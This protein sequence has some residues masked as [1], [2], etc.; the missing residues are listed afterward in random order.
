MFQ[1]NEIW[2]VPGPAQTILYRPLA[3]ISDGNLGCLVWSPPLIFP[4]TYSFPSLIL[5][6]TDPRFPEEAVGPD[7]RAGPTRLLLDFTVVWA[8]GQNSRH[9]FF[10][11]TYFFPS[12]IL[13][14]TDP[15]VAW[16]W[17]SVTYFLPSLI[18]FRHLFSRAACKDFLQRGKS[19]RI[20]SKRRNP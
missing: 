16:W 10:S 2:S 12:L 8:H 3:K 6:L 9:L 11:V 18:F 4:V 19:S 15:R 1:Q 20:S 7:I 13:I 17:I 14:W 5:I